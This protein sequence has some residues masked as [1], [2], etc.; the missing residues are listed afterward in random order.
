VVSEEPRLLRE[1]LNAFICDNT[2]DTVL[3]MDGFEGAFIGVGAQF[4]QRGL[5]VYSRTRMIE[6]LVTR[7]G[8]SQDEADEYIAYNCEGAYVGEG[9]PIIVRDYPS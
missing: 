6:I 4:N 9:T 3:L 2:D 8:M 7:D 5:A 1:S